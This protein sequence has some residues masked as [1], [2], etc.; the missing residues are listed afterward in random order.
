MKV[1]GVFIL[2]SKNQSVE[3]A[4]IKIFPATL[5]DKRRISQRRMLSVE[6]IL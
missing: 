4:A 3:F 1:V 5:D 2:G 6:I